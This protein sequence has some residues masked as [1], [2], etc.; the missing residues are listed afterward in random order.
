VKQHDVEG[1]PGYFDVEIPSS[2]NVIED[3]SMVELPVGPGVKENVLISKY[4]GKLY[5]TGA[6]STYFG[7]PL[8]K[9]ALFDD[10]VLCSTNGSGFSIVTGALEYAPSQDG[11]P[12]YEIIESKEKDGTTF[13][14]IPKK[15][16]QKQIAKMSLRDKSNLQRFIIVGNGLAGLSCA[17]TLR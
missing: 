15:M 4:N 12:V 11:I 8:S 5:A 2:V 1:K 7:T 16:E 6:Y 9:G 17:E 13:V 3:G 10:K 14:R